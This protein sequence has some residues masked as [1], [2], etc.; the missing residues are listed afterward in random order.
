M[1]RSRQATLVDVQ[2]VL[3]PQWQGAGAKGELNRSL[4]QIGAEVLARSV[5]VIDKQVTVVDS[6]S[7]NQEDGIVSK[8]ELQEQLRSALESLSL[9]TLMIGGDCAA[10]LATITHGAATYSESF[11][12]L[13]LDAHADSNTPSTSPSGAFHGMVLQHAMGNGDPDMCSMLPATI[14]PS[15]VLLVGARDLDAPEER[16]CEEVS[17]ARLPASAAAKDVVTHTVLTRAAHLHIHLDLDVLD[18]TEFPHTTYPTPNGMSVS[19]VADILRELIATGRVVSIAV[20]ES[21]AN[22]E[23]VQALGPIIAELQQWRQLS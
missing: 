9:P 2:T 10:D 3:F 6:F 8:A 21:L 4:I 22:D 19:T 18:P 11:A 7:P 12:V 5:G 16:W 17:L 1:G 23:Q 13:Y 14:D 15:C 20:T